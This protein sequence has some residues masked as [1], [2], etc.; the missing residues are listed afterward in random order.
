MGGIVGPFL[1]SLVSLNYGLSGDHSYGNLT[2]YSY[3]K[4]K[5][6]KRKSKKRVIDTIPSATGQ[7]CFSLP[8][9]KET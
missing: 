6:K 7:F 8:F 1:L 4:K 3:K 2:F 5:K 9:M